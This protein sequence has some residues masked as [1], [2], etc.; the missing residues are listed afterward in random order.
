MWKILDKQKVHEARAKDFKPNYRL[1]P[2]TS[3]VMLGKLDGLQIREEITLLINICVSQGDKST[4]V[5]Q[6]E[7]QHFVTVVIFDFMTRNHFLKKK[8]Y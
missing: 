6:S 8:N 2:L 7:A 4:A 3:G 5:L 1:F